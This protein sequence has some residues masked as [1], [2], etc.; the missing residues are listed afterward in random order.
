MTTHIHAGGIVGGYSICGGKEGA[1]VDDA[2][3]SDCVE[4]VTKLWSRYKDMPNHKYYAEVRRAAVNL[5][6]E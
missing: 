6:V 1:L 3:K 2:D 5:N 4:C